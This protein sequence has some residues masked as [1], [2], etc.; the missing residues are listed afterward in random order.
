MSS[1]AVVVRRVSRRISI[2][3]PLVWRGLIR[4]RRGKRATVRRC[5][6]LML[7]VLPEILLICVLHARIGTINATMLLSL[8]ER[9]VLR[10]H[11]S[12]GRLRRRGSVGRGHDARTDCAAR[13]VRRINRDFPIVGCAVDDAK[14]GLLQALAYYH[15]NGADVD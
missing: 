6:L 2:G 3:V 15:F 1:T 11:A 9:A 5:P 7:S 10:R 4:L 8:W 12:L 14:R 13:D